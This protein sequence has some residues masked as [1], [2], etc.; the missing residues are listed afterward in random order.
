MSFRRYLALPAVLAMLALAG[1]NGPAA[2]AGPVEP[3][4]ALADP[5][6]NILL[7]NTDDQRATGT[8]EVMPKTVQFFGTGGVTY[9]NAFVTTSLCCPSRTSLFTGRY[10]H[11]HGITGNGLDDEVDALDQ[12]QFIQ[13]ILQ[14][15]GYHT[16]MV[17]KYLTTYALSRDP[18]HYDRWLTTTGGYQ[19]VPY[20]VDS[21]IRTINGYYTNVLGDYA[22]QFLTDFE[23]E[24]DQPWFLY[25]APQAPHAGFVPQRKY[26]DAPVPAWDYPE[27][28]NEADISDKPESWRG[29]QNAERVEEIRQSQL[30]TLISVDNML[31]RITKHM[32][33]LDETRDTIAIFT[34][35]NGFMWGEHRIFPDK[36]HPY[37]E[38]V[39]VPLMIRWPAQVPGGT[40]GSTD[41]RIVANVDML[42]TLL[43]A[44]GATPTLDNPI[45][46][47]SLLSAPPRSRILLEYFKSA[48]SS[49]PPWKALRTTNWQYT[50]RYNSTTGDLTGREY[51]NLVAD[52]LQLNNLLGDATTANDPDVDALSRK[53]NRVRNCVAA[54][55]P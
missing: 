26:A 53:L 18:E 12:T 34:S 4:A 32:T 37:T 23:S 27:S 41:P 14:D 1:L 43:E 48:D 40:P 16:A 31:R 50:E 54:D 25:V 45:D 46:G 21:T 30:R 10:A 9:P 28:F 47:Q 13:A 11:N 42:P 2:T 6:P 49:V 33:A 15:S 5:R 7:I 39:T 44:A 19:D 38:S 55:C 24:D 22:T 20:N 3:E 8:M 29:K 17:G 35:D 36:R 51:Y 52:P